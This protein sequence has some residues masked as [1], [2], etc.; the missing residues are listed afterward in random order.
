M[1]GIYE[2]FAETKNLWFNHNLL[3]Q[4]ITKDNTTLAKKYTFFKNLYSNKWFDGNPK[5]V[6]LAQTIKRS[7]DTTKIQ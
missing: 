4:E 7:R 1:K 2:D 6:T 5:D 3:F